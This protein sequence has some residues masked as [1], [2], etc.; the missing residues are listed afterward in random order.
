MHLVAGWDLKYQLLL[1]HK[2]FLPLDQGLK[3]GIFHLD[4]LP[5]PNVSQIAIKL[6]KIKIRVLLLIAK[7]LKILKM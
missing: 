5:Y 2:I 6:L 3:T 7:E 4:S 1:L